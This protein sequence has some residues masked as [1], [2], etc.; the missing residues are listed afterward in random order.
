MSSLTFP[1][2]S[3]SEGPVD[4]DVDLAR[5]IGHCQTHLIQPSLQV[6]LTSGESRGHWRRNANAN[7]LTPCLWPPGDG[8]GLIF[9]PALMSGA[10]MGDSGGNYCVFVP[11]ATGRSELAAFRALAASATRDG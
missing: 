8:W 9:T 4:D 6:G 5:P 2:S 1:L 7:Q 10:D 3:E 11:E